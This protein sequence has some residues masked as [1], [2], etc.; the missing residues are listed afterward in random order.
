ME[1]Q[2]QLTDEVIE[3]ALHT[4]P[5]AIYDL[6]GPAI[7]EIIIARRESLIAYARAFSKEISQRELLKEPLKGSD[8]LKGH[9]GLQA[10]FECGN[11]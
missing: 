8:P 3:R 1:L 6:D 7:K 2:S 5:Q 11:Q 10:C 9:G 4:W